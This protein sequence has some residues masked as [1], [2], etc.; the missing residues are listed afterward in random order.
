MLSFFILLQSATG[1]E[2]LR[3]GVGGRAV[4]LG[5]AY[6][7]LADD[8]YG[9]YYNPSGIGSIESLYFSSFYGRWFLDTD[10]GSIAGA[11]PIGNKG[12]V[13]F[14]IRGLYTDRIERRSEDDPWNYDYYSSHF[15]N[16]TMAYALRKG[17][18]GFGVGI[19]G[20]YGRIESVAGKSVSMDAGLGYY[21]RFFNFGVSISNLG[22]KFLNAGLPTTI[23]S[24][25]CIEP[26]RKLRLSFDIV[27]PLEY[28]FT[29]NLGVEFVPLDI[30]R[31]RMGYNNDLYSESMIKKISAGVGLKAGNIL[32]DYSASPS[33]IFGLTHYL[34]LS[35]NIPKREKGREKYL[36]T[37]EKMMSETYL[38]QGIDY[39]NQG[40]LEE[41]LNA[42]DLA[43][44]WEPDNQ[45]ALKWIERTQKNIKNGRIKTFL[46]D[47]IKEFN[48]GN[49]LEAIYNFEKVLKMDSTL[50][51]VKTWIEKVKIR[52]EKGVPEN[53]RE[54]IE[55]GISRFR[56]GK[57]S[58]AIK[59]WEEVLKVEPTDKKVLGYLSRAKEKINEEI[60]NALKSSDNYVSQGN[61][62]SAL[63]LVSWVLNKYPVNEKLKKQKTF[64]LQKIEDRIS[65][66]ISEGRKFF[67]E[68]ENLKAEKKFQEVLECDNRN[69]QALIYLE[70]LKEK[71]ERGREK[72]AKRYYLLGVEAYTKYNFQLA[73]D[74]WERVLQIAPSYPNVKKNIERAK[75]KLE[76]LYE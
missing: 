27:K 21:T 47:G 48:N 30:L 8:P 26:F 29:Y 19:G 64:V 34:S 73:I 38:N 43:L 6:C 22:T 60:G 65:K 69:S 13:G 72:G 71:T 1:L 7:A 12:V 2:F 53:K 61:L 37:N 32:V 66:L 9:I 18:F 16:L 56:D 70:R 54:K 20:I 35:F 67:N 17:N 33:G 24:G 5:N 52:M 31:L 11:I 51:K 44:I 23:R 36:V 49:N 40:K 55:L 4:S 63:S 42:W 50:T 39:Y 3:I 28:G 59:I 74:Y 14:G 25:L 45:K 75:F 46:N 10:L 58:E 15:L 68:G 41:A 57:Y 62:K 76:K